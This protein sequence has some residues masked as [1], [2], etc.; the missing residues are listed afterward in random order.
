MLSLPLTMPAS[1]E[2][3]LPAFIS[4]PLPLRQLLL[5]SGP[6]T[7]SMEER[8]ADKESVAADDDD[9]ADNSFVLKRDNRAKCCFISVACRQKGG[10][11]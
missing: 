3:R 7:S 11:K 2:E 8:F 1:I 9:R 5:T 4:N 6:P 10:Q